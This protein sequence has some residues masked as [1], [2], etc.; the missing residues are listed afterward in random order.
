MRTF[1]EFVEALGIVPGELRKRGFGTSDLEAVIEAWPKLPEA[2]RADIL[3][4]IR[5]YAGWSGRE[6]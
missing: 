1:E 3:A 2:I 6:G 4:M 5:A